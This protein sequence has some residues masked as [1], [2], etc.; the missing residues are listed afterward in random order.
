MHTHKTCQR[1]APK[2]IRPVVKENCE[3]FMTLTPGDQ[4]EDKNLGAVGVFAYP[5]TGNGT[6]RF[7]EGLR[8][9]AL[10]L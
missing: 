6:C 3:S 8:I 7:L 9:G 10:S 1:R 4:N 5:V 2:L